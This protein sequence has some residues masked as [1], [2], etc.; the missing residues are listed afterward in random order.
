MQAVLHTT[1]LNSNRHHS[2]YKS[3]STR[4]PENY[5]EFTDKKQKGLGQ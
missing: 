1:V 2:V 3:V 4:Y 5:I